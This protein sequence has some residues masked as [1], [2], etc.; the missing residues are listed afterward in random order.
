MQVNLVN[1]IYKISRR[2]RRSYILIA[3]R[4]LASR[5]VLHPYYTE[6]GT[7]VKSLSAFFLHFF[8]IV[9]GLLQGRAFSPKCDRAIGRRV[10]WK[11][12]VS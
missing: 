6:K 5:G 9:S 7:V 11:Y 12:A 1:K 10:P 2:R 3:F 4:L 8:V